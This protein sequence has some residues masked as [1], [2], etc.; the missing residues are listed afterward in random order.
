[1]ASSDDLKQKI[2]ELLSHAKPAQ[3][4]QHKVRKLP[5]SSI[6]ITGNGNVVGNS[7]VVIRRRDDDVTGS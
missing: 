5:V 2:K 7:N 3:P 6:N 4:K 1:M